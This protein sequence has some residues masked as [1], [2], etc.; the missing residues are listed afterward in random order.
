MSENRTRP[1]KKGRI[2]LSAAR[3]ALLLAGGF[4]LYIMAVQVWHFATTSLVKTG[5]LTAGELKK[6]YM[7]EGVLIRNETVITSPAD[8]ELV[9]LLKPG[10]RVRAGDNIAEVRT[11]G[12]DWGIPARSALIRA[13][14]TGV[15]NL[16]VDGLEG[17]LNPAQTD[18]LEVV[19]LNQVKTKGYAVV[20]EGQRIKCSKGQAVLKIVDNLSPL[21]IALQAPGGFPA[22]VMKKGESIT[23]LWE[24]QEL[25]GSIAEN[26]V[27]SSTTGQWLVIR[28]HSYP[29]NLMS[30]RSSSFE[31][32]GGKVS[33]CIVSAK[34][35]VKKGGQEGL[36]IM[37]KQ[38]IHW[39]PVKVEGAVNDS[40]A[41]SG[42]QIAPGVSYVLNPNWLLTG[43]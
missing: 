24:N 32:V 37:T 22:G 26:P 18:I 19:K 5:A 41:V 40:A 35:L 8:G 36:Y 42:E 6:L 23:M 43:N 21:I 9:L 15:I 7:A 10:E 3:A 16:A 33:G 2:A 34:S 11:I 39:V 20:R 25:T 31:L 29:A 28:L 12:E 1:G 13:T 14:G 30:I 17:V 4:I 27:V 38:S